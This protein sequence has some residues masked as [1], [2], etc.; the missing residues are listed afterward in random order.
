MM[1]LLKKLLP[2]FLITLIAFGGC[3]KEHYNFDDLPPTVKSFFTIT[4]TKLNIDEP[5]QF[6]NESENA[7]TYTWDFGDGSTSAEKSPS[8]TYTNPGNY[9]VSLKA[10]G[11][12][13]TGNYSQQVTVIDPN[14]V[15]ET[16]KELYFIEYGAKTIMK[17]SLKP[18][19][20]AEAV[21]SIAGKTGPGLA[22]DTANKKIYYCDFETTGEGK[23]WRMNT[24]GTGLEELVSGIEDPYSV[25]INLKNG[26]I[27]WADD[28]GNIS[29]ANL[30]GSSVEKEF[31]H[32][33]SGQMRAVAYNSKTDLIYFYEVNNEDLYVAKSDGTGVA[34]AVSGVY[35]YSIFVDEVNEKIYYDDRNSKTI[36]QANLDGSGSVK[37]A[38]VTGS[39]GAYGMAIDYSAGKLYWAETNNNVIKRANLDGTGVETVLSGLNS[40]RGIFIK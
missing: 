30:D 8:K 38:D 14:V 29:R 36:R 16:D 10:V 40:P 25:A 23:I 4:T 13:G 35:G 26:K 39:R 7:D 24:D 11:A 18:G 27:Y 33:A 22:Y 9:I 28:A 2:F 1:I 15:V 20:A 17:I 37:I 32:V 31:I 34:K 6:N 12:G 19:S 5:I 21:L 3:K